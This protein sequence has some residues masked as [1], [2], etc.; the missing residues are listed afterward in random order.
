M[1]FVK[2]MLNS[3]KIP[4]LNSPILGYAH[5]QILLDDLS[6]P[7]DFIY[8]DVN[9]TFEKLTGSN[10]AF[11]LDKPFK[12]L[13]LNIGN[14]EFDLLKYY[15]E[16]FL[17]GGEK[18]FDFFSKPLK[19]WFN[20][21]V[22]S[23]KTNFLTAIFVDIN[24]LNPVI[25]NQ[26]QL[27]NISNSL[28][29]SSL[30]FI[31]DQSS[32]IINVNHYFCK[33]TGYSEEELIGNN[34]N[35]I[36][37]GYHDKEFWRKFW[38]TISKGQKW[39]GEIKNI[40]K[41]GREFWLSSVITPIA[42]EFGKITNY[43]SIS[44]DITNRKKVELQLLNQK[45]YSDSLLNA[46]PD[47]VFVFDA[48]GKFLNY[49]AGDEKELAMPPTLF[50][51][52]T[53]SEVF[54][55]FLANPMME[56][57]K[58]VIKKHS[59][60]TL[61]YKMT[62]DNELMDFEARLSPY[63]NNCAFVLVQNI[64]DR[65]KAEIEILK[66]KEQ[67]QSLVT[68]IPGITYRCQ[69]DECWTMLFLSNQVK[70]ITGYTD[71]ELLNN[72]KL[73]YESL[74]L[75]EDKAYHRFEIE[76]GIANNTTWE[77]E[78]R[79]LHKDGSIRW[80]LEKGTAIKNNLNQVQYLDGFIL[81][82][83]ERKTFQ[84]A[85][86]KSEERY[87]RA[88]SGTGAGLWDWD[89]KNNKMFFSEQW[90]KMLGYEDDEI[91]NEF[92]SWKNLWHPEETIYIENKINNY[93]DGKSKT[94]EVE[95]RLR[96]KDGT[97]R[98]I[99]TRGNIEKNALGQPIRWTGTNIDITDRKQNEKEIEKTQNFLSQIS[100][101]AKVGGW[102][103]NVI[104][105]EIYWTD[106]ICDIHEI[107]HGYTPTFEQ[108][109]SF[110]T[111]ESW[112]KLES[113]IQKAKKDRSNY[114]LELQIT[115][116]K[117]RLIWVRAIGNAEFEGE[118]CNRLFG[119]IQDINDQKNNQEALTIS[120]QNLKTYIE[121]SPL[122]IFVADLKG[123]YLDV[124]RAGEIL[125]GYSKQELLTLTIIDIIAPEQLEDGLAIAQK[126]IEFGK[127]EGVF[128]ARRKDGSTFWLW[129][130]A[131]NVNN[132]YLLAFCQDVSDRKQAELALILAKQQAEAA[133][134]AK[135]EF[136]AN[137]SH[138][139]RT[140]LNG[141]IGFTDLLKGTPLSPVQQQYVNNAN[142]SGHT[143]LGIINDIL[144]FS[145]IE[146]G[147][148]HLELIKTDI[149]ELLESSMDIVKFQAGQKNIELILNI[150]QSMP[151]FVVT[152]ALRLKQVLANLLGNAVKFT[153]KGEVE[154][155]VDYQPLQDRKGKLTFFVQDTGI[156]IKEEQMS[157]LFK[158][159]SQ[160]DSSTT[161][162]FGG[163]GLGLII[164]DLIIKEMGSKIQ[165][166]SKIGEGTTFY[167]EIVTETDEETFQNQNLPNPIKNCLII[168]DNTKSRQMLEKL[169]TN[170]NISFESCDN[171]LTALKLLESSQS[172]DVIIC[173][174]NMPYFNGIETIRMIREK[175]NRTAEKQPVIMLY[176]SSDNEE[177]HKQFDD[178]DI[179]YRLSKPVKRQELY[180]SLC[181]INEPIN[182]QNEVSVSIINEQK[183][184]AE[185]ISILIAE[186]VPMNMMMIKAS[187]HVIF[188]EAI[189]HEATN[190][191]EVLGLMNEITPNFIFMDVQMPEMDGLEATKK[192]RAF[193]K[194]S[195]NHVPIIAL[196]AGAFKE[197]EEKCLAAGMDGFMTKPLDLDKIRAV[198]M[199]YCSTEN[200][201]S[202]EN[203]SD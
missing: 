142:V 64:T 88:I 154:L 46:I 186:D 111:T 24:S 168:D 189:I 161:R 130:V 78:Y 70:S 14:L 66:S 119:V 183:T 116:A 59:K 163:T 34:L 193:E 43:I 175:L 131:Q 86:I 110:Y 180:T 87:H 138:E 185:S 202:D 187:I 89:I 117:G 194:N 84:N 56:K 62:I 28:N 114:D 135:S 22:Y 93:L 35:I 92:S 198:L 20:V 99:V 32:C 155:K 2:E 197:E 151:R 177:L 125:T 57:L 49:K 109:A 7:I 75:I 132:K 195:E 115:T 50:L 152:D 113:A 98:W 96:A 95:H 10:G 94:Y 133:N 91:L 170:W 45:L 65:K 63:G 128:L 182:T 176:S 174:S 124:N 169:I 11:I 85:L 51:G 159:F 26:N 181:A 19:K 18:K 118:T 108:M 141:V 30:V 145:K 106:S 188:P 67:Y 77:I 13:E 192:I 9:P 156:G 157:K 38:K 12:T 149:V 33:L 83:T 40:S 158:A 16:I 44:Q 73:S 82:I 71:E 15:R 178:L 139:I 97:W 179:C 196:T 79:I 143:L 27:L 112:L 191:L 6:N 101:V 150:H 120:E 41:D 146:A 60:E 164:S 80:V 3:E 1:V 54:P 72:A 172:F 23:P 190:G 52:K 171:G 126:T 127:G 167:F 203:G 184:I 68:N 136:L 81:D 31:T 100:K 42:D 137:M 166:D 74:I 107:P 37:S 162:K 61:E 8:I 29:E 53:L 47:L 199:Q 147:M 122:G 200:N 173:D 144:D 153:E 102:D 123:N 69:L 103:Y 121:A 4:V 201:T 21:T 148:L 160:A 105:G 104:T 55:P 90:K 5:L 17:E 76:R 36:N 25:Q 134:K 129:L 165:V 58:K 140:P 48:E 39:K